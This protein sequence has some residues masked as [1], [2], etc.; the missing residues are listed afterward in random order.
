MNRYPKIDARVMVLEREMPEVR[1]LAADAS[2]E[3]G[4]VR[5]QYR[6]HTKLLEA[7]RKT[8]LD[9]HRE[10]NARFDSQDAKVTEQF[11]MLNLGMAQILAL[12]EITRRESD[13][14]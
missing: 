10:M 1:K 5:A 2:K 7:L 14:S 4:D 11:T 13:E 9:H 12:M 3:V 8:Q 6:A